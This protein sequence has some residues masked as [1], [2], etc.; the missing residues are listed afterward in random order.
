MRIPPG[1]ILGTPLTKIIKNINKHKIHDKQ[2]Y[3]FAGQ[4][5]LQE[6]HVVICSINLD[7]LKKYAYTVKK[8]YWFSRLQ[9]GCGQ[10]NRKPFLQCIISPGN[11]NVVFN[12]KKR[13]T[14]II[15]R[16]RHRKNFPGHMTDTENH[17]ENRR[18]MS[19]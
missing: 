13:L 14:L 17:R 4:C 3:V 10:E 16:W 6:E 15:C 19:S 5:N 18:L 11:V 2:N 12:C 9:P 8:S 1:K 7:V